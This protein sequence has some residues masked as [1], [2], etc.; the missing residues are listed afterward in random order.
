MTTKVI[1]LENGE[2]HWNQEMLIPI[3][4]PFM[5]ETLKLGLWD[6][7]D[8]TVIGWSKEDIILGSFPINI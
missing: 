7:G 6:K 1:K 8:S 4:I 2:I 3:R 5:T